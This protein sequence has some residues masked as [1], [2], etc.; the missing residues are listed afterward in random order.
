VCKSNEYEGVK[1]LFPDENTH[2]RVNPMNMREL[3]SCSRMRLLICVN[4]SNEYEGVKLMF[5][6]GK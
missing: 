3:N 4:Q 2:L 1:L 6:D 5:R